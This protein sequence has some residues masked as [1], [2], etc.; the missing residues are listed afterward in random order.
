VVPERGLAKVYQNDSSPALA[1]L[2]SSSSRTANLRRLRERWHFVLAAGPKFEQLSHNIFEDD[3]SRTNASPAVAD[4]KIY[5]RTD[6]RL[7]C[8][9]GK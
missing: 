2:S 5:L 4:G 7:Y 6:K 8:I 1:D 3:T 9:G